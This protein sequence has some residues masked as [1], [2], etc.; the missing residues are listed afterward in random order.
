MYIGKC[1]G[2]D[3]K[4]LKNLWYAALLHDLGKIQ[5]PKTL[6]SK[7]E[8]LSNKDWD[9]IRQHPENGSKLIKRERIA[10]KEIIEGI[11]THHE[12]YSGTGYPKGLKGDAIPL[13]GRIISIADALDAMISPRPYRNVPLVIDEALVEIRIN[14]GTQFDPYI[15]R[16]LFYQ[17]EDSLYAALTGFWRKCLG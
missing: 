10:S 7:R 16:E 13:F 2:L 14:T 6:L 4:E 11:I 1:I 8:R 9:I 12:R 15:V 17:N 5:I 3:P